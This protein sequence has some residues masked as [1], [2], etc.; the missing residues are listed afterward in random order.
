VSLNLGDVLFTSADH[1]A[2]LT[3]RQPRT[4]RSCHLEDPHT[5]LD[6]GSSI[7]LLPLSSSLSSFPPLPTKPLFAFLGLRC[8]TDRQSITSP[9]SIPSLLHLPAFRIYEPRPLH[10]LS[11]CRPGVCNQSLHLTRSTRSLTCTLVD[12]VDSFPL[13]VTQLDIDCLS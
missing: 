7:A 6:A 12:D 5:R 2:C 11:P 13:T 10:A 8:G 4:V 3:P 1:C 9:S